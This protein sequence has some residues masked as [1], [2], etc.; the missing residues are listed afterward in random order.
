[1]K[2]KGGEQPS[3]QQHWAEC[4]RL[5]H[6]NL[7]MKLEDVMAMLSQIGPHDGQLHMVLN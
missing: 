4:A 2:N 1:M 5:A 6:E 3:N 7:G